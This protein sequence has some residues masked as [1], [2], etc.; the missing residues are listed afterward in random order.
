MDILSRFLLKRDR[1]F[2]VLVL[3][4]DKPLALQKER[5]RRDAADSPPPQQDLEPQP[6][7]QPQPQYQHPRRQVPSL[8]STCYP[9]FP[10]RGDVRPFSLT[11]NTNFTRREAVMYFQLLAARRQAW[12]QEQHVFLM[13]L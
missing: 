5:V 12:E 2:H 6:Q 11:Q 10:E 8:A 3:C 9:G 13:S 1:E 4:S 7:P